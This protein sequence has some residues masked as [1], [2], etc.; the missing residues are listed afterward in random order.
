MKQLTNDKRNEINF[1]K[2]NIM[3]ITRQINKQNVQQQW[4]QVL[5]Y[6]K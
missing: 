5:R 1:K 6:Q 4:K 2:Y 3:T